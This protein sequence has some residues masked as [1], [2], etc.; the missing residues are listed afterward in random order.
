M[1]H[2]RLNNKVHEEESDVHTRSEDYLEKQKALA[3]KKKTEEVDESTLTAA[4][5][6]ERLFKQKAIPSCSTCH[7]IDGS[8][9]VGPSLKGVYGRSGK[10][11]DGSAYTADEA[12]IK[13]AIMNP[14]AKIIEGYPGAMPPYAGQLND[15]QVADLIEYFK[16]LK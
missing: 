2:L 8:K 9:I 13:E 10:L 11:A 1:Y 5:R 4:Q 7:S 15:Q 14:M 3:P 16:T 12:Y 6:G